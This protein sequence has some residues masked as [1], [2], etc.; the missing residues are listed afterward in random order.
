MTLLS[1]SGRWKRI[2]LRR[3]GGM[4]GAL[5]LA[6]LLVGFAM[7]FGELH[8]RDIGQPVREHGPILLVVAIVSIGGQS[9]IGALKWRLLQQHFASTEGGLIPVK[10]L[11][12]YSALTVL[13]G[14]VLPGY[15]ASG[16]IRG[17]ATRLHLGGSFLQG[18]SI[19][20]YD[21]LFDVAVLIFCCIACLALFLIGFPPASIIGIVALAL[22]FSLFLSHTLFRLIPP[23]SI[24]LWLLS[25]GLPGTA[26]LRQV[27]Q[28]ARD[29]GLDV[30][31]TTVR[32]LSLSIARY[33]FVGMRSVGAVLLMVPYLSVN[34]ATWG[35][36]V[37]Q[38][39][40]LAA[41]TPGNVGI[42]EWSW[43]AA[44]KLLGLSSGPVILAILVLRIVNIP[45]TLAVM[46]VTVPSVFGRAHGATVR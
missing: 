7:R 31:D 23:L 10:M 26:T 44:A 21:Q 4:I 1:P 12:F 15:L 19:T 2:W 45:A 24:P 37:V 3:W 8:W 36:A 39:S 20:I 17:T 5:L 28:N 43:A 27:L 35:F 42:T 41:L 30:P 40:A 6:I 9:V 25:Q 14:Q 16:A 32:L 34:A 33:V 11:V 29:R 38:G 13:F 22:A 46:F 18:A